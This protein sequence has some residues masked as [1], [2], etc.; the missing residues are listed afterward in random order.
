LFFQ[1]IKHGK[2]RIIP[3]SFATKTGMNEQ[4]AR[5]FP[6]AK[7]SNLSGFDVSRNGDVAYVSEALDQG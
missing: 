4:D 7:A 1:L 3:L 2:G 6:N 5:K